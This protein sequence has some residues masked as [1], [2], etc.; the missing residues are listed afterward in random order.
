MRLHVQSA[1]VYAALPSTAE[2]YLN[3]FA[4]RAIFHS[5]KDKALRAS[6]LTLCCLCHCREAAKRYASDSRKRLQ[7]MRGAEA[8][9][10]AAGST[11]AV[12]PDSEQVTAA[13]PP[14]PSIL[15]SHAPAKPKAAELPAAAADPADKPPAAAAD[16]A[17]P[18]HQ[19]EADAVAALLAAASGD[20]DNEGAGQGK[21]ICIVQWGIVSMSSLHLSYGPCSATIN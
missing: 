2:H 20:I 1:L 18:M 11:A 15:T 5:S 7:A 10:A 19:D 12:A 16:A 17:E 4:C 14:P 21:R 3:Q 6:T 8:A 9:A 13:M